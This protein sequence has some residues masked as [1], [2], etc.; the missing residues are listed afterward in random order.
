MMELPLT[1]VNGSSR[2]VM[3]TMAIII[4]DAIARCISVV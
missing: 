2:R 1:L 4:V 3:K